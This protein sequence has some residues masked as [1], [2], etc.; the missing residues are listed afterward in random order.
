MWANAQVLDTRFGWKT[1]ID[2][3][4]LIDGSFKEGVW[5][6]T[7]DTDGTVWYVIDAGTSVKLARI[8]LLST[9][10]EEWRDLMGNTY[11][12]AGDDSSEPWASGNTCIDF[13]IHDSGFIDVE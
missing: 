5:T 6:Q 9:H 10:I 11:L 1:G 4:N 8:F 13:A 2:K 7:W 3:A 12:C